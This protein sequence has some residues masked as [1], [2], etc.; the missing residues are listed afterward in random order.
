MNNNFDTMIT[1]IRDMQTPILTVEHLS[2]DLPHGQSITK[3]III[4]NSI[5]CIINFCF[6]DDH[7]YSVD[8]T[9]MRFDDAIIEFS[10]KTMGRPGAKLT[11]YGM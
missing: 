6:V 3:H 9:F 8:H 7:L 1:M 4:P 10:K 2:E 5:G 11:L